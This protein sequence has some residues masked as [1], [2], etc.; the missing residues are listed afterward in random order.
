M[1]RPVGQVMIDIEES[2]FLTASKRGY[3]RP[4][5]ATQGNIRAGQG[6]EGARGKYGQEP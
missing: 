4:H 1:V 2:L 5:R 3:D 6:A